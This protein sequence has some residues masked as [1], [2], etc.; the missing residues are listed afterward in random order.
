MQEICS[1]LL[2]SSTINRQLK[3][4]KSYDSANAIVALAGP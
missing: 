3:I 2:E 1:T 4:K